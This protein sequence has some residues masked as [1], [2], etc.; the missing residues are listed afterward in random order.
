MGAVGTPRLRFGM[1]ERV[2]EAWKDGD[3]TDAQVESQF[4][5]DWIRLFRL[6]KLWGLGGIW[7]HVQGVL[8]MRADA[9][10]ED[11]VWLIVSQDTLLPFLVVWAYYVQWERGV[12]TEDQLRDGHG[13]LWVELFRRWRAEGLASVR[14]DLDAYVEWSS[15]D[16]DNDDGGSQG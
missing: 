5:R 13:D 9:G 1:F 15:F 14:Q 3:R 2:Y 12:L 7:S 11:P 10:P 16:G 6:W 8:D 4:G